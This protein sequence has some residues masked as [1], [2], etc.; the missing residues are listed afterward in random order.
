MNRQERWEAEKAKAGAKGTNTSIVRRLREFGII[1]LLVL[2]FV[3]GFF[4]LIATVH[5]IQPAISVGMSPRVADNLPFLGF[6]LG[7][8]AI[9]CA[10]ISHAAME[11][12]QIGLAIPLILFALVG[13]VLSVIATVLWTL[14]FLDVA[15]IA[16]AATAIF[17]LVLAVLSKLVDTAAAKRS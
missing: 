4:M 3:A 8:L 10:A 16:M 9:F 17:V 1:K 12:L 11:A 2:M 15:L 14:A 13:C 5:L 7:A 6:A